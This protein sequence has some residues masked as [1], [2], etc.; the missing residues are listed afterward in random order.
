MCACPV[1]GGTLAFSWWDQPAHQRVQGLLREA[2]AE[3]EAFP[4][5]K[6]AARPRY[7]SVFGS[8]A[9]CGIAARCG[10]R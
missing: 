2:I 9:L 6:R 8:G 1:S 5:L 3:L 7:A 4:T 10:A